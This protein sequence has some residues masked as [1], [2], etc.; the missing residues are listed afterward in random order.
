MFMGRADMQKNKINTGKLIGCTLLSMTLLFSCVP[1]A[2]SYADPNSSCNEVAS[3]DGVPY[4]EAKID[5]QVLKEFSKHNEMLDVIVNFTKEANLERAAKEATKLH[6][7]EALSQKKKKNIVNELQKVADESQKY[8]IQYLTEEKKRGTVESWKSY[9]VINAIHVRARASVIKHLSTDAAISSIEKNS[10]IHREQPKVDKPKLQIPTFSLFSLIAL[11]DEIEWN[12][13]RVEAP[14]AWKNNITGKGVVIGII[15]SAVDYTHKVLRK[16]FRGYNPQG[17]ASIN[18]NY[19]DAIEK[20]VNVTKDMNVEHGT[21]VAGIILGGEQDSQGN[22]L[23]AIGVAPDAQF[24]NARVFDNLGNTNNSALL[25]AGQWMLAPG[26]DTSKAPSVINNS[27]GGARSDETWYRKLV[28]TWRKAGIFPVFAAGNKL[29]YEQD[30]GPG[31]ISAPGSYPE[32]FAVGAVD[33]KNKL[34]YFSKRGPSVLDQSKIKP[35]ISAPGVQIRSSVRGGFEYLSGTSMAAP[36]VTGVVALLQSANNS[37]TN[38]QIETILENS[39]FPLT[40]A[41]YPDHPNMGYGYGIVNVRDALALLNGRNIANMEGIAQDAT[42]KTIPNARVSLTETDRSVSCDALTGKFYL[43]QEEGTYNMQITA[44]GYVPYEQTVTL[45]KDCPLQ[46]GTITLQK[47]K[48]VNIHG[49]VKVEK[50]NAENITISSLEGAHVQLLEDDTVTPLITNERGEFTFK[51]IPVGTYTIRISSD[52]CETFEKTIQ[53]EPLDQ[54]NTT[55][56]LE[57]SLDVKD[58]SSLFEQVCSH[59]N[60]KVNE[61]DDQQIIVGNSNFVG[62]AVSF[63]PVKSGGI[64]KDV[65]IRTI[66]NIHG[67]SSRKARLHILERDTKGRIHDLIQPRDIDLSDTGITTVNLQD[68]YIRPKRSYYVALSLA[69]RSQEGFALAADATGDGDFAYVYSGRNLTPLKT[70][71]EYGAPM[72]SS[73]MIFQ[74]TAADLTYNVK[75]PLLN[76][77]NPDDKSITG[78]TSPYMRVQIILPGSGR[79][80]VQADSAGTFY[81]T[82]KNKLKAGEEIQA[83]VRSNDDVLSTPA[84][85]LVLTSK[86]ELLNVQAALKSFIDKSA[87]KTKLTPFLTEIENKLS[88]VQHQEKSAR[89]TK[90]QL[91]NLQKEVDALSDKV[92]KEVYA[93]S[94]DKQKLL[95]AIQEVEI[96][97]DA[98]KISGNGTDIDSNNYWVTEA[99]HYKLNNKLL[100]AKAAYQRLETTSQEAQTTLD[101]LAAGTIRFNSVKKKGLKNTDDTPVPPVPPA[102]VPPQPVPEPEHPTPS[103][104][105]PVLPSP[106][107]PLPTASKALHQECSELIFKAKEVLLDTHIILMYRNSVQQPAKQ[108]LIMKLLQQESSNSSFKHNIFNDMYCAATSEDTEHEGLNN[109]LFLLSDSKSS[110]ALTQALTR[111]DFIKKVKSLSALNNDKTISKAALSQAMLDMRRAKHAFYKQYFTA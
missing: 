52:K 6:T 72:I 30:P 16:K 91:E 95:K 8:V 102:P 70:V 15:D 99:E 98:T 2:P 89:L 41:T 76:P 53:V 85:R 9:Y 65:T 58:S 100:L 84:T 23:N 64:L 38:T 7:D 103:P 79:I 25:D 28:Q 19:N 44:Y 90:E 83:R 47:K 105:P 60:N 20:K 51:N 29:P 109:T 108:A 78:E 3:Q 57:L 34:A 81:A 43:Q 26:G 59:H 61:K 49:V 10:I 86:E 46:L 48:T 17:D 39:A 69:S 56:T 106:D 45:K 96:L 5:K 93:Y 107:Q 82:L 67:A 88:D 12:I 66:P 24:I 87:D 55:N 13:K 101:N 104:V 42:G 31:S 71:F 75:A 35:E 14:Y 63:T 32:S 33:D 1:I 21:H 68:D 97:L 22:R 92:K 111:Q 11:N 40:D 62:C 27:W 94:P 36:H 54:N 50:H 18:G 73:T 110:N 77:V 74:K 80:E 37:L 4:N